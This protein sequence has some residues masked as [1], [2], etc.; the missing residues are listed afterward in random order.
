M[1]LVDLEIYNF[2]G[3]KEC[4][5]SLPHHANT[6]CLIGAG[7]STKTTLL[8]AI[9]WILWPSWNLVACD[10]DFRNGDTSNPIIL[11]GTF[12]EI[13]NKLMSEDKFGLH[14]RRD[15][16][17][18]DLSS[19]DEPLNGHP[20]CLTIQL[21]IDSTLEPKWEV[22]CNRKDPKRISQAE[23]KLL[24]VGSVGD[25]CSKDMVWSRNSV[26]QK[27][28]DAKGVLHDAYTQSL[29]EAVKAV[30][31]HSL[32]TVSETITSVGKQYGVGF[33]ADV[34]NQI[35]MQN[36]SFTSSVGLFEGNAPL[37]QRGLGSQRLLSIGL[38][39][40]STSDGA[41]LLVDEVEHGLEPYRLCSLINEFRQNR[42]N[43][44][45]IMTTHSPIAVAECTV[46][47]L[48]VVQSKDGHSSVYPL[49]GTDRKVNEEMQKQVRRNPEAFLCKRIII[50]EG[51]TEKGF[52]RALDSFLARTQSFRMAFSGVGATLG[53]GS[54]T[55]QC[56]KT[57]H[58]CGYDICIFMDS[59]KPDEENETKAALRAEG[60][61]IFDWDEPNAIEEQIF[62]DVPPCVA[63]DLISIAVA[64]NGVDSVR[65]KL[66]L[67]KDS[68]TIVGDRLVF[69]NPET[70]DWKVIGSLAKKKCLY[71]RIDL[72]EQIGEI[73]FAN[74]ETIGSD[75]RL[76]KTA[77]EITKWVQ[78]ND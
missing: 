78:A 53:D 56:A 40:N 14:L 18:Y 72:G 54:T 35:I 15:S 66:S 61:S 48:F 65:D 47:E 63:E 67:A 69:V 36:S 32:D 30:D 19:N 2:R 59:D 12:T 75:T 16:V 17:P 71:K 25:N 5:F 57:F 13:P 51:K 44:Q 7:D 21:T 76:H 41:L 11:R 4:S 34:S 22:V 45:V 42:K 46:S 50:C 39:I 1:K 64:E 70:V 52:I 37:S 28:A 29:R 73:I 8:R 74:W 33:G 24:S 26:L 31:L 62:S 27:Y 23:R 60:I 55:F 68:F 6:V 58:A 3:I 49:A 10:H 77:D 9:E 20:V 43:G 38:N